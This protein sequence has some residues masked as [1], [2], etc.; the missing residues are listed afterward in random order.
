MIDLFTHCMRNIQV[1]L[2]GLAIILASGFLLLG[3]LTTGAAYS[4][5]DSSMT[6]GIVTGLVITFAG[7]AA[8]FGDE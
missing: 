7:L 5:G 4:L 2:F 3:Q 1:M 8:G 6:L